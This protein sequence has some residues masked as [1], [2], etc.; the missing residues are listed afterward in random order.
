MTGFDAVILGIVEGLTEFLPVSS[1][2]H[3]I[4]ASELLR[5]PQTDAHKVFEVAIQLGAILAVACLYWRRFTT[6]TDLLLKLA[7]GFLPTGVIGFT[8]YRMVK[9]LFNSSVVSIARRIDCSVHCRSRASASRSTAVS[10]ACSSHTTASIDSA[11][12]VTAR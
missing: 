1:T 11:S 3:L 12:T 8:L 9:N 2:G 4:L 5:L 7:V 10:R 6:R